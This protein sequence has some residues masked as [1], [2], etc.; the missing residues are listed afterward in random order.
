MQQ[1]YFIEFTQIDLQDPVSINVI[2]RPLLPFH[3][4]R[5]YTTY[6][7]PGNLVRGKHAHWKTDQLLFAINGQIDVY[8]EMPGEAGKWFELVEKNIG[9]LVPRLCWHTLKFHDNAILLA[10][11]SENY[12]EPDYIRNYDEF[13]SIVL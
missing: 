3:I 2:E 13:K 1:P 8:A 5:V 9:L 7:T 11:A 10:L 12:H 4:K 6:A